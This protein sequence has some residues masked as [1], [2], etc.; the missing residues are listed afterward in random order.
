MTRDDAERSL[1]RALSRHVG[2]TTGAFHL[3]RIFAVVEYFRTETSGYSAEIGERL[4]PEDGAKALSPSYLQGVIDFA[5]AFGLIERVSNREAKLSR[6]AA[7]ELGRSVLG[8]LDDED[9]SFRAHYLATVVMLADADYLV[10]LMLYAPLD[11]GSD[12][13]ADFMSF[14]V[15]L[16]QRRHAWLTAALTQ[17]ILLER[18]AS[19]ISWLK[20]KR[21][22]IAPFTIEEPK[23]STVRHHSKPRLGWLEALGLLDRKAGKLTAFGE[24]MMRAVVGKSSYFWIGPDP[25]VMAVL[26]LSDPAGQATDMDLGLV[27]PGSGTPSRS[28]ISSLVIDTVALMIR[29]YPSAKLIHADQASLRLPIAF[30]QYRAYRDKRHYDWT[31]ILSEIFESERSRII[32][33]SAHKGQI[34]FYKAILS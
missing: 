33:Y 1:A 2:Y 5:A 8:I 27:P 30:I 26:G 16:R 7:T 3:D 17:P 24:D 22:G 28:E 10:P 25:D 14:T 12:L 9:A 19:R 34:G 21:G 31:E 13:Q 32:R 6:Y 11:V 18:V 29:A 15:E 20:Q 4:E 23:E